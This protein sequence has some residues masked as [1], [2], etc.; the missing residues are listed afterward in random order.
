MGN[1]IKTVGSTLVGKRENI[2]TL[3]AQKNEQNTCREK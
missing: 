1:N 2:E 3:K